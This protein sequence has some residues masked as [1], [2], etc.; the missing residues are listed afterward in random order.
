MPR[1]CQKATGKLLAQDS[2]ELTSPCFAIQRV[3]IE[4][5]AWGYGAMAARPTPDQKVGSSNLS[6]LILLSLGKTY[7]H[8][9]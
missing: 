7:K 6:G 1:G 9:L 5:P 2:G 3:G 8:S 4:F